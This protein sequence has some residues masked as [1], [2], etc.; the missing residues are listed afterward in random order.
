MMPR[1]V[2]PVIM[3]IVFLIELNSA[4]LLDWAKNVGKAEKKE[5]DSET[6]TEFFTDRISVT[7]EMGVDITTISSLSSSSGNEIRKFYTITE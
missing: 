1:I 5:S 6:V 4:G 7:N 3:S 2:F